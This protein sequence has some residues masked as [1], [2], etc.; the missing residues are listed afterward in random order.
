LLVAL[1]EDRM[2]AEEFELAYYDIYL[3]DDSH[4]D[5]DVFNVVDEFFFYTDSL[6]VDPESREEKLHEIGPEELRERAQDLLHKAGYDVGAAH[7]A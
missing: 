2:S 7:P 3:H 4:L 6:V 5:D 1:V